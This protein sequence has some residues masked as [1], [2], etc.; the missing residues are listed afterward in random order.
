M[1]STIIGHV[2]DNHR[3]P[4]G[5]VQVSLRGKPIAESREDG[6]FSV[7]LSHVEQRVVLTFAARGYVTNTQVYDSRAKAQ[8]VVPLW[9]IA[10]GVKFDTAR[11]L[12][13][14]LGE[15]HVQLPAH[16]LAGPGHEKPNGLAQLHYTWFDVTNAL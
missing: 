2:L 9:P 3:R 12:D 10:Y 1:P 5:K 7:G 14:E 11:D 16:A 4:I 8:R 13:I 15:S 6:S